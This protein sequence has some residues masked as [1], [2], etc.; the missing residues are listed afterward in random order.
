M[1]ENTSNLKEKSLFCEKELDSQEKGNLIERVILS[2]GGFFIAILLI[3]LI[4]FIQKKISREKDLID[5]CD[6]YKETKLMYTLDQLVDMAFSSFGLASILKEENSVRYKNQLRDILRN[7]IRFYVQTEAISQK[8]ITKYGKYIFDDPRDEIS[9]LA[10][11][12]VVNKEYFKRNKTLIKFSDKTIGTM[13]K[14]KEEKIKI[15]AKAKLMTFV[16]NRFTDLFEKTSNI[17]ISQIVDEILALP[18][19]SRKNPNQKQNIFFYRFEEKGEI[20]EGEISKTALENI[21]KNL[22]D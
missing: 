4:I 19:F 13:D 11:R 12:M 18:E 22:K 9:L 2:S 20:I 6:E 1:A 8:Y 3:G 15:P 5:I 10:V 17:R 7:L 16:Y 14:Y 21:I